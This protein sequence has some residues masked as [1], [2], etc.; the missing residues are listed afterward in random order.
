[1]AIR[2]VIDEGTIWCAAGTK[3]LAALVMGLG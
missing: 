3:E 2:Q 1:M